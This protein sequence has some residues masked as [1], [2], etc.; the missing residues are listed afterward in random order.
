LGRWE[1]EDEQMPEGEESRGYVPIEDLD[2]FHD[3]ESLCDEIWDCVMEWSAFARDTVGLQLVR[4]VDSIGAN[5]AEGDGRYSERESL[6]FFNVAKGSA[7]EARF[8]LR[9]ARNR[10]LIPLQ[11]VE[12]YLTR[13]ESVMRRL[14]A[15]V[16][17]RRRRAGQVRERLEPYSSF[18]QEEE[19]SDQ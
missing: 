1:K 7:R 8:W 6:Q 16:S 19:M 11:T 9:R 13:L 12:S 14:S 18:P 5:L 17:T 4:A 2:I 15:L 3:L 10:R